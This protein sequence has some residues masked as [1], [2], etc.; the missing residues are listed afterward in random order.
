[1]QAVDEIL[2][3]RVQ[4]DPEDGAW[5]LDV[6]TQGWSGGAVGYWTEDGLRREEGSRIQG[7]RRGWLVERLV[8]SYS[9][10]DDW[11]QAGA[12]STAF[13]CYDN[14]GL[15][16]EVRH[17]D[18]GVAACVLYGERR[19]ALM[20]SRPNCPTTL[21]CPATSSS[22]SDKAASRLSAR[23]PYRPNHR[24]FRGRRWCARSADRASSSPFSQ[25]PAPSA[26]SG[27]V[28]VHRDHQIQRAVRGLNKGGLAAHDRHT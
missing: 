5:E 25:T 10:L 15:L 22:A 27:P 3:A 4:C 21:V 14:R 8:G 2:E 16:I 26:G 28:V 23:D 18:G 17:P 19:Q 24:P 7:I 6:V 12:R 13:S 9:I 1:M 11:R 20:I